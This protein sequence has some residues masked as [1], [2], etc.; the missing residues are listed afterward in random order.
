MT[1]ACASGNAVLHDV[2]PKDGAGSVDR[3]RTTM[4]P[5]DALRRKRKWLGMTRTT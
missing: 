4:R 2:S 5:A 1:V 3:T